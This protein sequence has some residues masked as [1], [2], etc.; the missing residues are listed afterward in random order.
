MATS[1]FV[2][3]AL[4]VYHFRERDKMWGRGKNSESGTLRLCGGS[5]S[6]W[7]SQESHQLLP[8]NAEI[9]GQWKWGI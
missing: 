8:L 2:L 9:K 6:T 3:T 4:S 7:C 1:L 5:S